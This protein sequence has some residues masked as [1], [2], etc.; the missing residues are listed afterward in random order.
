MAALRPFTIKKEGLR[1]LFI[2]FDKGKAVGPVV[3]FSFPTSPRL[4]LILWTLRNSLMAFSRWPY[5]YLDFIISYIF[6]FVNYFFYFFI[7]FA[8]TAPRSKLSAQSGLSTCPS[9]LHGFLF[10]EEYRS[11]HFLYLLYHIFFYL[12]TTFFIF[13]VWISSL[14]YFIKFKKTAINVF[15]DY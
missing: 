13:F 12:S 14:K 6:L 5:L 3:D 2:I 9:R 15:Y 8:V 7:T 10:Y 1:L 4:C 11:P